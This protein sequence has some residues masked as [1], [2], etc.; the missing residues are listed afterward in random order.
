MNSNDIISQKLPRVCRSEGKDC[1]LDPIR[2]KLICVT[3]EETVRQK[4][5]SYLLKEMKIPKE[6]LDVEA[7]LAD[8]E[9]KSPRRADILILNEDE[10]ARYPIAVI[11]CKAPD[12]A[13]DDRGVE[14]VWDYCKKLHAEY[15]VITN[16]YD[17]RFYH[18]DEKC[19]KQMDDLPDYEEM[20]EGKVYDY[21]PPEPFK[22]IPLL[23]YEYIYRVN[24]YRDNGIIGNSSNADIA[25]IGVNLYECFMDTKHKMPAGKYRLFTLIED[26][27]IRNLTCGNSSG[28]KF[29]GKYRSFLIK[30]KGNCNFVSFSVMSYSTY[31]KPD[32]VKT[33]IVIAIDNGTSPHNSLEYALDGSIYIENDDVVFYHH[34]RMAVGNIGSARKVDLQRLVKRRYPDIIEDG[35]ICLGR[36]KMDRL[37]RLDLKRVINV[38]ENMISYALIRD[39]LRKKLKQQKI[40]TVKNG[41]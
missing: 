19:F 27:G 11:E 23:A 22:R 33:A 30:Y 4:V 28:G 31:S 7:A 18:Y 36:L 10:E 5:I 37:W 29:N 25:E 12:V 16:S 41:G 1:Y 15:A 39:D 17:F 38:M 20:L 24:Q 3:P 14:Q 9:V 13:I 34:G 21:T 2:E 26:Y 8:Y 40:E 6:L 32:E 35:E